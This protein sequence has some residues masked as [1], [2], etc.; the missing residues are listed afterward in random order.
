MSRDRRALRLLAIVV[1]LG[2]LAQLTTF[3]GPLTKS[4]VADAQ[5][6]YTRNEVERLASVV[7]LYAAKTGDRDVTLQKLVTEARN[8]SW[9]E[10]C[11]G[12]PP[13]DPWGTS[14]DLRPGAKA[15]TWLV[16]S[17]GPDKRMDTDD[18]IRSD[19]R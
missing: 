14:Y 7:A 1:G 6:E 8:G 19:R 10:D 3:H 9:L 5:G 15:G 16:R 18:D 2:I 4:Y 17:A 13:N 11:G 12:G